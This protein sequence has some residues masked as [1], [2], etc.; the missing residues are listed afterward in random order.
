MGGFLGDLV[1]GIGIQGSDSDL[2]SLGL[3]AIPGVGPYMGQR[4]AN[5]ANA[6]QSAEQMAFQERMS[7]TAHQREV[8]DLEAAGLNP[9]L[10]V[11]AGASTPAG[12]QAVMGN[13]LAEG[14][15]SNLI[16]A[17]QKIVDMQNTSAST[18]LVRS[19]KANMDVDTRVKRGDVPKSD[20]TNDLY[21]LLR[22]YVQKMK[23]SFKSNSRDNPLK[24]LTD[25]ID[26][27][28]LGPVQGPDEGTLP[29][30]YRYWKEG[31][32]KIFKP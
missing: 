22:P 21:D 15:L 28:G 16:D 24:R 7:S 20:L 4:E 3:S 10:S 14:G 5:A 30:S 17:F 12:S 27:Q 26:K 19:Q 23:S 13:T 9:L 18:D 11:N 31:M 6:A 1:R 25:Q 29:R 32:G 8:A 2:M